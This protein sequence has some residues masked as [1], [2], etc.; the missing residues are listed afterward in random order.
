MKLNIFGRKRRRALDQIEFPTVIGE[1]A[2][3]RGEIA[4][5]GNY[6]VHG[7]VEGTCD[8]QGHLMLGPT[9]HWTGDVAATYIVIAG[10]V[11]G[12]VYASVKLELQATAR[13]RGNLT[14]PVIAIAEGAR[15]DGKVRRRPRPQAARYSEKRSI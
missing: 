12:D 2:V 14:S 4:G 3:Y 8:I 5:D 1:Y 10:E 13:I 9:A 11:V 6:L 7:R 15:Y